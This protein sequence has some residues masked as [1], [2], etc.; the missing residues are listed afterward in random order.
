MLTEFYFHIVFIS[1]RWQL[2]ALGLSCL[3]EENHRCVCSH[4][5]FWSNYFFLLLAGVCLSRQSNV[6]EQWFSSRLFQNCL[7]IVIYRSEKNTHIVTAS[8]ACGDVH[9]YLSWKIARAWRIH[10]GDTD[11]PAMSIVN[12]VMCC[13][14]RNTVKLLSL[15]VFMLTAINSRS[16]LVWITEKKTLVLS[17]E[18]K[19]NDLVSICCNGLVWAV[20]GW[21]ELGHI[22]DKCCKL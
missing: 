14:L 11:A 19:S 18:P 15:L 20:M 4:H 7:K 16:P 21:Y 10:C 5:D 2:Y 22:V 1:S 8:L 3:D 9:L 12:L 6:G 17:C 13:S